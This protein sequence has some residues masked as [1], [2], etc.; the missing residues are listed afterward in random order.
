LVEILTNSVP[1]CLRLRAV[2]AQLCRAFTAFQFA[3]YLLCDG[4]TLGLWYFSYLQNLSNKI[5]VNAVKGK[6]SD[7]HHPSLSLS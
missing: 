1:A 6:P 3:G 2:R 7:D 5:L 4:L